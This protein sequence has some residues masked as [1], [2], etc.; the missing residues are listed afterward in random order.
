MA[1]IVRP[2]RADERVAFLGPALRSW[3]DAYEHL[4]PPADVADAPAMLARAWERRWSA[5]R[6]AELDG[7]IAGF[8]SLGDPSAEDT[9][10]YLWH[11]YVDPLAQRRGVGRALNAAALAEIRSRGVS[12]AWL[13]VLAGNT[14]ARAFY[15]ALGWREIAGGADP[16]LMEHDL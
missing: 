7:R 10:G 9:R 6:V 11:L 13:D 4:L 15:R 14:R 2:V 12:R 3:L 8:Y 5:F 16:V 1:V